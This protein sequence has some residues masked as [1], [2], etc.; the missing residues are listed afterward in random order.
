MTRVQR[1]DGEAF[2]QLVRRYESTL[3]NYLRRVLGNAAEA[4]EVFQ[5]AFLRVHQH[6]ARFRE[7]GRFRPWL[8]RIATNL[9]RD[10]QRYWWRR[11]T[12]SLDAPAEFGRGQSLADSVANGGPSPEEVAGR[13]ELGECIEAA[14]QALPVRQRTVFL[15]ARYEGMSYEEISEALAIPIGTVKSRM[16][17]AAHLLADALQ[18]FRP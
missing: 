7:D 11:P 9:C 13:N 18:E 8:Y 14:V 12:V 5:E 4:E 16:N 17:K 2:A 10:R 15:M 3:F 1:G 6:R